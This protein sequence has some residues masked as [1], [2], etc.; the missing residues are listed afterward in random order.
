MSVNGEKITSVSTPFDWSPVLAGGIAVAIDK[1]V[2]QE[3]NMNSSLTL[4]VATTAGIYAGQLVAPMIPISIPNSTLYNGKTLELRISEIGLGGVGGWAVNKYLLDNSS[5][6]DMGTK[7]AVIAA[8][9]VIATYGW[10]YMTSK[11]LSYLG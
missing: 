9:N 4:G 1:F 3:K 5:Y 2:L 8:S 11:P 7:I 10:E 6:N